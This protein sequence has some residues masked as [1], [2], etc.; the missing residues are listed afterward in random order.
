MDSS[1]ACV[2]RHA[3]LNFFILPFLPGMISAELPSTH[4]GW[5]TLP[6]Q[7]MPKNPSLL[8]ENSW[9]FYTAVPAQYYLQMCC[10]TGL[11]LLCYD[12]KQKAVKITGD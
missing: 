8:V 12:E 3:T 1:H 5:L 6:I 9:A 10:M 4:I 7:T 2:M 11:C